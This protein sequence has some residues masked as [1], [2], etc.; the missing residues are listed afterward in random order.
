MNLSR[1]KKININLCFFCTFAPIF[2]F[3]TLQFCFWF[4]TVGAY[5]LALVTGYPSLF[6]A[7]GNY[8]TPVAISKLHFALCAW[9][10]CLSVRLEVGRCGF[11]SLAEPD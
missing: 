6:Y 7:R 4:T 1:N 11:D 10:C 5:Y 2:H 3:T 8:P 9:L